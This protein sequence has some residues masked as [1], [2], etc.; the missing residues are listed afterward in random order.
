MGDEG[1]ENTMGRRD[2]WGRGGGREHTV[3]EEIVCRVPL[4]DDGGCK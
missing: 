2:I 3:M 4:D 1:E